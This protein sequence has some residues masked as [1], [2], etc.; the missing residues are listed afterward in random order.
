MELLTKFFPYVEVVFDVNGVSSSEAQ[1]LKED[2]K[3]KNQPILAK[4]SYDQKKLYVD[5]NESLG[6][7]FS[8]TEGSLLEVVKPTDFDELKNVAK[9]NSESAFYGFGVDR[10]AQLLKDIE[11]LDYN[12][13]ATHTGLYE[14]VFEKR[15]IVRKSSTLC[16]MDSFCKL[17]KVEDL[18]NY[19]TKELIALLGNNHYTKAMQLEAQ[20]AVYGNHVANSDSFLRKLNSATKT[21]KGREITLS[22]KFITITPILKVDKEDF[23]QKDTELME[24]YTE[25]QQQRNGLVKLHKDKARELQRQYD[26]QYSSELSEYNAKFAEYN[27]LCNLFNSKCETIKTQLTQ[28]VAALKIR[29]A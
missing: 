19:S 13:I 28:E 29:V 16:N 8:V 11:S 7:S 17:E 23:M 6:D 1:R 12:T 15:Q 9:R 3:N 25:F 24:L 22:D 5:R 26:E 14:P 20:A 27:Q 4:L 2:N 21:L 18:Y 10:K